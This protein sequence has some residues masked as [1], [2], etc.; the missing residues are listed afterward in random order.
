V[1]KKQW[2]YKSGN[3]NR[4]TSIGFIDRATEIVE[5]ALVLWENKPRATG[6]QAVATDPGSGLEILARDVLRNPYR[7]AIWPSSTESSLHESTCFLHWE[8]RTPTFGRHMVAHLELSWLV[9]SRWCLLM[10]ATHEPQ[11]GLHCI[12]ILSLLSVPFELPSP[13]YMCWQHC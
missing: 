9:L 11:K 7:Q 3:R 1:L 5:R 6:Q 4:Q 13:G 8:H 10:G 2:F 12:C